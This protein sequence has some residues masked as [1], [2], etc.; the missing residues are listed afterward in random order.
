LAQYPTSVQPPL[1]DETPTPAHEELSM[2]FHSLGNVLELQ[3]DANP[4]DRH[5]RL[6]AA[7]ESHAQANKL[8]P[9]NARN[10]VSLA[11]IHRKRVAAADPTPNR[12]RIQPSLDWLEAAR[13]VDD[14][15][16]RLYN[17]LGETMLL[18]GDNEQARR[19]FDQAVQFGNL[20]DSI[21]NRYRY[22]CNQSN[23]Y[24][25]PPTTVANLTKALDAAKQAAELQPDDAVDAAYFQGLALWS[26]ALTREDPSNKSDELTQAMQAF[27]SALKKNPDHLGAVLAR[28]QL[29]F[30]RQDETLAA[31]RLQSLLVETERALKATTNSPDIAKAHYVIGLGRLRRHLDSR[32]E[33]SLVDALQSM[34]SAA[35]TS[36]QYV[37]LVT[38][39]FRIAAERTWRNRTLQAR[40]NKLYQDLQAIAESRPAEPA[41]DV[42]TSAAGR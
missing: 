38:P 26:L 1:A 12:T 24:W 36:R 33:E 41:S 9:Q 42:P 3:A 37:A 27:D 29:L 4:T 22:Y 18:L 8:D 31:E 2:I 14:Q 16:A 28:C 40:A 30:E 23:A 19:Q 20:H 39:Y 17:E 15:Y 10:L 32:Q 5:R 13:Q 34:L 21:P 6:E 35:R 7:A 11:R 25:R